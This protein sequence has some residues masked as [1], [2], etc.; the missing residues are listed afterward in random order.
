MRTSKLQFDNKHVERLSDIFDDLL[1]Y[2]EALNVEK[3]TYSPRLA[4]TIRQMLIRTKFNYTA[5][6]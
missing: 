2:R 4:E 5:W 6:V 1:W 3:R